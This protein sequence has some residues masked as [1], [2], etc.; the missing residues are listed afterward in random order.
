MQTLWRTLVVCL[1]FFFLMGIGTARAQVFQFMPSD[2]NYAA[3]LAVAFAQES[4]EQIN[5]DEKINLDEDFAPEDFGVETV[6]TL[7][8]SPFYFIK[9]AR[10]GITSFFTF[11]STKKAELSLHYAS[12]KFVE[13]K[14]LAEQE[15]VPPGDVEEALDNFKKELDRVET[16]AEKVAA[17]GDET[18]ATALGEDIM[19]SVV[20][21]TKSLD[22]IEKD[23]PP[24]AFTEIHEAKEKALATFGTVGDLVSI[25]VVSEKLSAILDEQKGSEFKNFKNAEVL[26]EL[27]EQAS[28]ELQE[29]IKLT[30]DNTLLKLQNELEEL[31]SS[32]KA[33]FE[34][35][36]QEVGGNEL[37][38]LEII[39]D[40][41]V[42]PVSADLREAIAQA[43]EEALSRAE[44]RITNLPQD[45]QEKFWKHLAEGDLEDV[46]VVNELERNAKPEALEKIE[47]IK[48]GVTDSFIKKFDTIGD[49]AAE[50]EKIL[51]TVTRFHDAKSI[52]IFDEIDALIP[53]DKKGVFDEIKKRA[54]EEIQKDFDR[55][56]NEDQR[57][58]ILDS[59]AGDHPEEL[60]AIEWF[61]GG[62]DK[63]YKNVFDDLAQTQFR[64]IQNRADQIHDKDRLAR[65]ETDVKKSEGMFRESPFDWRA[66]FGS[67]DDKKRVFD[68][69]NR[70]L[71]KVREAE[72][73]VADL[74][75]V[76]QTLPLD[77]AFSDGRFDRTAQ[78][79]GR[80]LELAE[81][82][83]ELARAVLSY[84]DVGR[85]YGEATSAENF[86]RQGLQMAQ[87]YKAGKKRTAP[88][89]TF[90]LPPI[91]P[92]TG[93]P[94]TTGGMGGMVLY[95]DY[96][97]GQYCFYVGGFVKARMYCALRDGR[98]FD[99]RGK[100]FPLEVPPEYIP[101][102][103]SVS[104]TPKEGG[105]CPVVFAPY[106]D[107]CSKG[108]IVYGTDGRGCSTEPTCVPI[109]DAD[110]K[111]HPTDPNLC[112]GFAGFECGAGQYC[113][114]PTRDQYGMS[115]GA[116][117]VADTFG[118]CVQGNTNTC[119]AYFTG[120]VV[121][122]WSG[123]CTQE[124]ASGCT[125]PFVYHDFDSCQKAL[126]QFQKPISVPPFQKPIGICP[127][128]P[129]VNACPFGQKRVVSYSTPECGT[130][131]ACEP[132]TGAEPGT[133]T[134][135]YKFSNGFVA[136][137]YAGAK[138]YC[139]RYPPGSGAGI[140][141]ECE[142]KFGI[143]YGTMP[144][145]TTST[146]VRHFWKFSDGLTSESMILNR[147]DTEYTSFI[148][149]V[150]AQCLKIPMHKFHWLPGAGNDSP[151]NW[152]NFGIPDCSGLQ[153]TTA[154]MCGN[155]MCEMGETM[156]SCAQDCS[157]TG[158]G[159]TSTM[160]RCFY[161][162]AS[163]NGVQF[164]Y[165]IWCEAD[166]Y[167][168]HRETPTGTQIAL[169]GLSL[170][171][172]SSCEG[173]APPSS[174]P[175]MY[176]T[177][178]ACDGDSLCMW[179]GS[180]CGSRPPHC[181][182]GKD[183]D[184]DG[185]IDYPADT[186][187]SSSS[188]WTETPDGGTTPVPYVDCAVNKTTSSCTAYSQCRWDTASNSCLASSGLPV[189][190]CR[191]Y[192]T[193][194]TCQAA[195][196]TWY[197]NHHDGTHCDDTAHGTGTTGPQCSD[198]IDND[199]DGMIDY[200]ADTSC[201]DKTDTDEYY[202]ISGTT[203]GTTQCSDGI[204]NDH[205]GAIDYPADT[206]C[207]DKTDTDEYYPTS[208]TTTGDAPAI[209]TGL[210]PTKVTSGVEL[211]WNSSSQNVLRFKIFRM[212]NN[213]WAFLS[214][215]SVTSGTSG[216]ITYNDTSAPTGVLAYKVQ[217]CHATSCSADSA[218]SP[219]TVSAAQCSDGKDNDA[220][221]WIDYPSDSG[222]TSSS[223][224]DE[225]YYVAPPTPPPT[226]TTTSP[227][228]SP[229]PPPTTGTMQCSDGI[230]ND[231]D[232]L[233]DYPADTGCYSSS[234]PDEAYTTTT[235]PPPSTNSC[236][237]MPSYCTT[238]AS[239]TSYNFY[240][241]NGS[242]VSSS[243]MCG[244]TTTT[245][246]PPSSTSC[247]SGQYWYVPSGST[248][249]Y[250]TTSSPAMTCNN[251]GICESNESMSSCSTDCH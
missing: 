121:G 80:L 104:T 210:V 1:L 93:G 130:Y 239:C 61:K 184:G 228:P 87:E 151:D 229:T 24:E 219:I 46:R 102:L 119:Q 123:V 48:R 156:Q 141:G 81:R 56:R 98:A 240:W 126:P 51:D 114:Y 191:T 234:D 71:E 41:E 125:D 82:R 35:F 175:C 224:N 247:P 86:A 69:P 238:E 17:G 227:T 47:G 133:V 59:L 178:T 50:K 222:C 28:A 163:Q 246:S 129:T 39:H 75:A 37:R 83:I 14:T 134:Y 251:N 109:N 162:N 171:A 49:D 172:P 96:E 103:D 232:A 226:S 149:S 100:T 116:G 179:G 60:E 185:Q 159:T 4:Q 194:A 203:T 196:C 206:S 78:E 10:R 164:G 55:A 230:D 248:A 44:E 245:T 101:K 108:K 9:S 225:T 66:I 36:V 31:D 157:G 242:C 23:L 6:G 212:T 155:G 43:K 166:Y 29:A 208:G 68:S 186:G 160:K 18:K 167:N 154:T 177:Q 176:Y 221:G 52:A 8:N 64:A 110:R 237:S 12:E 128:M 249:G 195:Y 207:Y 113:Q 107:F 11:D 144:K 34:D 65:F 142:M 143:M 215:M 216:L 146:W 150:D 138:E 7:P 200:P 79:I 106:G 145:P 19:D 137:D 25:E 30:E 223:D 5:P 117:G 152:K 63:K 183:N 187:C 115:D 88:P 33:V 15:G 57:K 165:S 217:A 204:D 120:Y 13:A 198:G 112:G 243:S 189:G 105:R 90:F 209:P 244:S 20:K 127:A 132:T 193:T 42:R 170:G 118:K 122:E 67:L 84:D 62:L 182:D 136:N 188:D 53:A 173:S 158:G 169:D 135:P 111:T 218:S 180:G 27:G 94:Q 214:E 58:V 199:H 95:N 148:S 139:L 231:G 174:G 147:T 190:G 70:A 192:V 235:T 241:C 32:Q 16:R 73:V 38:H 220:D 2:E 45:Q 168:C 54:A 213:V 202:P 85:A 97:F 99:A 197:A 40:L 153:S 76:A 3:A 91:P 22:K 26:K 205:D 74:R 236:S 21:Y 124:H 233:I 201:Y 89:P 92:D 181:K 250:C 211:K 77:T 72:V 161:P 131:Y 140:A